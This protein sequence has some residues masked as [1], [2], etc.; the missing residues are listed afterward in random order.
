MWLTHLSR[1]SEVHLLLENIQTS[2]HKLR[3]SG[4]VHEIAPSNHDC[5]TLGERVAETILHCGTV[6]FSVLL[7]VEMQIE[8]ALRSCSTR[9][10]HGSSHVSNFCFYFY[11]YFSFSFISFLFLFL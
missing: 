11:F 6:V 2:E 8:T 10:L 3:D 1:Y 7:T 4:L 9:R 5:V